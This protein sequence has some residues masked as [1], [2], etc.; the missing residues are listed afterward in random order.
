MLGLAG[1]KD[2]EP[3]MPLAELEAQRPKGETRCSTISRARPGASPARSRT[4]P[5]GRA[6]RRSGRQRLRAACGNDEALYQR[7]LPFAGLVRDD[8]YGY[9]VVIPA[10][11]R[12]RH[13]RAPTRRATGTHYTPRSLTEPI[14]Q[15]TLEPLVYVG[16]AE[17]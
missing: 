13:R 5:G 1:T 11:Q 15:H 12:V 2:K 9:P 6:R 7:V 3:E 4:A 14:V 16:P 8:D 10:G 17:G